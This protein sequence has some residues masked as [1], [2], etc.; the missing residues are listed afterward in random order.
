VDLLRRAGPR[1]TLATVIADF[2]LIAL[3]LGAEEEML[4]RALEALDEVEEGETA[5][6]PA[7][8]AWTPRGS[9]RAFARLIALAQE[10]NI[11]IITTLNVGPDLHED[12]PGRDPE[13]RYNALCIFTRH[14]VVHV[15]QAKVTPQSFEMDEE[16]DGP[17]IGVAPYERINRVRL[18]WQDALIDTR[19]VICSDLAAFQQLSPR[20]LRCDLLVVLGNF[21]Y[22]AEKAASRLLGYAIATGAASTTFH[23][24]A[25]HVPRPGKPALALK[26]EEVMDATKR[27]KPRASW[28]NPRGVRSAFHVYDD[29]E[30]HDFASMCNLPR[31]GRIAV[32][33][34]RWKAPITAGEYPITVSL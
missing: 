16:P 29:A 5:F 17:E 30:A 32:P 1:A 26:V 28:P 33:Q 8:L 12:L 21:A 10:R 7:Y 22:G 4:D 25:F 14:G 23:V 18:D 3:Q 9:G 6:L 27:I 2:H 13:A 31:R 19:F 20:D 34:S 11:N 15:P 24:N